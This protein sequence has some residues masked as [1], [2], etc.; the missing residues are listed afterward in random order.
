MKLR[1]RGNSLRLRVNQREVKTLAD[2]GRLVETVSFP[3]AND[4]SYRLE[5]V[6]QPTA[7]ASF[8]HNAI[9][10]A[11]PAAEVR[12][13]AADD[14]I[15]LYYDLPTAA[16]PLRI[17]IEKDLECVEGPVDERDPEAF[18]RTIPKVC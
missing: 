3:S 12:R 16:E 4:L 2:G 1:F 14:S 9:S 7:L 11:V 5:T 15:G 18:A 13:W 10:I 6:D 8:H 17:M